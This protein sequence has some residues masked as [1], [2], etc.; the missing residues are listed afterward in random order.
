MK[1][2]QNVFANH[3][4]AEQIFVVNGMPFLKRTHADSHAR[5]TGKP[6]EV[7]ARPVIANTSIT[8]PPLPTL[9]PAEGTPAVATDEPQPV[10]DQPAATEGGGGAEDV[11][12][13]AQKGGKKGGKK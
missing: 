11:I 6:V 8:P 10:D 5:T 13:Q 2:F 9:P 12:M 4:D 1:D 3:P 7:V